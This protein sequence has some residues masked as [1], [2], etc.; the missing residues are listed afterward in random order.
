ML[1]AMSRPGS[2]RWVI[3]LLLI[4]WELP[5]NIF[6]LARISL[7]LLLGRVHRVELERERIMVELTEGAAVSLGLFVL[8]TTADNPFIPVGAENRDHEYGHSIQSRWLGPLYLPIVGIPS[9]ARVVYAVC[10]RRIH[11]RRWPGYYNGFPEKWADRLG[12]VN[13]SI[14][15]QP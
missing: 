11:G 1:R 4:G 14:R 7:A 15:P 13:V 3:R 5:Q 12:G 6:G 9:T 10:F 2:L 8:W